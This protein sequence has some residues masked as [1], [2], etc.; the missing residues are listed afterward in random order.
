[1]NIQCILYGCVRR[2]FVTVLSSPSSRRTKFDLLVGRALTGGTTRFL[3]TGGC[4]AKN[5]LVTVL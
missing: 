1:M 4:M 5:V 3:G 2:C